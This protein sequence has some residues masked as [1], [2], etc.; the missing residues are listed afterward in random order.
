MGVAGEEAHPKERGTEM[1][2]AADLR[3]KARGS[4]WEAELQP[5][6][7]TRRAGERRALPHN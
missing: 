4:G 7:Q 6:S 2:R 3:E 1:K 5:A